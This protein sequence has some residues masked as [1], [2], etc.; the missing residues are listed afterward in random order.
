MHRF[1]LLGCVLVSVTVHA[2][3]MLQTGR[4]VALTVEP[5]PQQTEP[6]H[7]VVSLRFPPR[8]VT[9]GQAAQ[10]ALEGTGFILRDAIHWDITLG[11]L[12]GHALPRVH[13]TLGPV[14]LATALQT[15][16]GPGF[17]VS[18]DPVQRWVEFVP[19]LNEA[20]AVHGP[21]D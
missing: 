17:T 7:E 19:R 5:L 16:V 3:A 4:Y 2:G 11:Q 1:I 15:L 21:I 6:L 14:P 18:V 9:V 20:P 10:F 8:I 12:F 13:R